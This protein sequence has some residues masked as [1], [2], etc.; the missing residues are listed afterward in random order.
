MLLNSEQPGTWYLINV[1][2]V[3][4]MIYSNQLSKP[5]DP[6]PCTTT[7][8]SLSFCPLYAHVC[9]LLL[10]SALFSTI[11]CPLFLLSPEDPHQGKPINGIPLL[12]MSQT[13]TRPRLSQ[14]WLMA[15][16]AFS[17][18]SCEQD[19]KTQSTLCMTTN[20]IWQR[21][22]MLSQLSSLCS[23]GYNIYFAIFNNNYLCQLLS[24]SHKC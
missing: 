5:S 14:S 13:F 15:S 18:L 10:R 9:S 3:L 17:D 1:I 4:F 6:L 2:F 22:A 21:V 7:L 23:Y 24:R 12:F 8:R 16:V 11:L 20:T 19:P